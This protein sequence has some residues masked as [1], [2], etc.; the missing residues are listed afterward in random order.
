MRQVQ[1]DL[2]RQM[3]QE[4]GRKVVQEARVPRMHHRDEERLARVPRAERAADEALVVRLCG[5]LYDRA[6][7]LTVANDETHSRAVRGRGLCR[8]AESSPRQA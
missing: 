6:Q 3:S 7:S 5:S 4:D 8:G 2:L 1:E